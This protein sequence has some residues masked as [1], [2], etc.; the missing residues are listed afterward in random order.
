MSHAPLDSCDTS[1]P[2]LPAPTRDGGAAR[3]AFRGARS[4]QG[5]Y[6]WH[7]VGH[8]AVALALTA[9]GQTAAVSVFIDPMIAD[10]G[11]SRSQVSAAYLVGTLV[12]AAAMPTVGRA[13]DRHGVRRTMAAI[14]A[15]FGAVLLAMS[16]ASTLVEVG[17][18]FVGIRMLG[19]GALG[20]TATTA[21][22]LWFSRRRGL[23]VGL[24]SSI[25]ASGISLAPLL[26]EGLIAEHGWRTTWALEGLV[27]WAV[28]VP[29]AWWGMRDRPGDLGQ[30]PEGDSPT[31][32]ADL[33]G[34]VSGMTR[35]GAMRSGFFWVV[36]AGVAVS[37]MLATAVGFHQISL[38]GERGMTAAQAAQNFVPQTVAALVATLATGVLVDRVPPRWVIS[39]AMGLLAG[40]LLWGTWVGPGWSALVFGVLIGASGGAIRSVEA[41]AFPRFFGTAH[42]GSIRG[43]VASVSV[44]STAFGPVLFAVV[45]ELTGAYAAALAGTAVLPLVVAGVGVFVAVPSVSVDRVPADDR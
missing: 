28:V 36:T 26:L 27:V 42:L 38:L 6:G 7:V 29:L 21:A 18:G 39:G 30:L 31:R 14:G 16:F 12:G 43:V 44:G 32:E 25:G 15:L 23:A 1:S 3:G 34:T 13:L 8:S 40:G 45:R 11:I 37:G 24:V 41:A 22:A 10:L 5:F 20:L 4:P 9:P 33:P 19:Q 2:P 35:A 17:V